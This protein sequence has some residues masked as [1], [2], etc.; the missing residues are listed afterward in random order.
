MGRS[1]CVSHAPRR[2]V[3]RS[4]VQSGAGRYERRAS[5]ELR[6]LGNVRK[7]FPHKWASKDGVR[8]CGS[9]SSCRANFQSLHELVGHDTPRH[10][11]QEVNEP[12]GIYQY[13]LVRELRE[14]ELAYSTLSFKSLVPRLIACLQKRHALQIKATDTLHY[15]SNFASHLIQQ[16]KASHLLID[17]ELDHVVHR[18]NATHAL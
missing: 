15:I 8:A 18:C 7:I 1:A 13:Q 9:C 17:H 11:H 16:P 12:R 2:C 6:H 4:H 10:D 3:R 5:Q 14:Q